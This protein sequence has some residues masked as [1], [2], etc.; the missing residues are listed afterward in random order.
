MTVDNVGLD[1]IKKSE[2]VRSTMYHDSVGLPTIGVG[3]LLTKS[4]LSAGKIQ[5]REGGVRWA[6]GLTEMQVDELLAR[7]LAMAEG[8][9]EDAITV[10]VSQNQFN[11]LVSF[12]F[13]VGGTAFVHSRLLRELNAGHKEAVPA[14]LRRWIYAGGEPQPGLVHRRAEEIRLWERI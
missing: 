1:S 6:N 10:P 14:Q 2:G 3:H 5:L 11:A 9:V 7:D 12:V 13:N 8:T 4:E